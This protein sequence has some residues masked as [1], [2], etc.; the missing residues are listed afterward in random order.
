MLRA[1]PRARTSS[2]RC[3]TAR[4]ASPAPQ[5]GVP[6]VKQNLPRSRNTAKSRPVPRI[7]PTNAGN[8]LRRATGARRVEAGSRHQLHRVGWQKPFKSPQR[9]R[10]GMRRGGSAGK[11]EEAYW[12]TRRGLGTPRRPHPRAAGRL[13]ATA[14]RPSQPRTRSFRIPPLR[15][16]CCARNTPFSHP[17]SR[18]RS[19]G[20]TPGAS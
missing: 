8:A 16:T 6:R 5:E 20:R 13:I 1:G 17:P 10:A 15:A 11:P 2:L 14:G 9:R 19:T 7:D 18:L 12:G 4:K 3:G